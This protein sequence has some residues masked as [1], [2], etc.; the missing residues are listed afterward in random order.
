MRSST[1]PWI[2]I[3]YHIIISISYHD[4]PRKLQE[5]RGI[6]MSKSLPRIL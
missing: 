5:N 4:Q 1:V 3:S 6:R 2:A